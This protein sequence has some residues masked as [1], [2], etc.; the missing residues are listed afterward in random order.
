L[1]FLAQFLFILY[2]FCRTWELLM[3]TSVQEL[4]DIAVDFLSVCHAKSSRFSCL[5]FLSLRHEYQRM[6]PGDKGGRCVVLTAVPPSFAD[7]VE[8][9][10]TSKSWSTKDLSWPVMRLLYHFFYLSL[11]QHGVKIKMM[12]LFRC[13]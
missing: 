10:G 7:C 6:S 8:I 5:F 1:L 4:K 2:I 11:V 3:L 9:L 12:N 13:S